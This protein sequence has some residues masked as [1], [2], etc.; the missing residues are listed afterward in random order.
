MLLLL[1]IKLLYFNEIRA[2]LADEVQDLTENFF[3]NLNAD[4]YL[5]GES[6]L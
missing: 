5:I 1:F 4:P 3:A 2:K 6:F